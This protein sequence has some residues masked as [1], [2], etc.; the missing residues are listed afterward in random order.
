MQRHSDYFLLFHGILEPK[1]HEAFSFKDDLSRNIFIEISALFL[2]CHRKNFNHFV[3][4]DYFKELLQQFT[5]ISLSNK[6][7]LYL[8]QMHIITKLEESLTHEDLQLLTQAFEYLYQHK[9]LSQEHINKLKTLFDPNELKETLVAKTKS[10]SLEEDFLTQKEHFKE[11]LHELSTLSTSSLFLS[12]LNDIEE[13]INKQTFSIGITGVMNAGKSTL[14]NALMGA[15]ILGSSVI[16]ETANLSIVKYAK[17]TYAKV[18][19]WDKKEWESLENQATSLPSIEK[20]IKQTKDVFGDTLSQYIATP[21]VEVDIK[22]EALP[23][24]TSAEKSGSKCNLVKYVTLGVDLD[25]LEDGIEIVD[26]PGLDDPVIQR[27][28]ITKSYMR[29]CDLMIHLMNVSQSATYKDVEF[30]IDALIYQ[31]ISSLLIIITRADTVNQ[32][33]LDEVIA[34]TKKSIE[35]ELRALKQD[36]KVEHILSSLIFLPISGFM[37][38]QHKIGNSQIAIEAG[39]PLEKTGILEIE[40]YLKEM[41]FGASSTKNRLL[42]QSISHRIITTI[43]NEVETLH[44]ELTLLNKSEDELEEELS[45]FKAKKEQDSVQ[46]EH[47]TQDIHIQKQQLSE[48]IT[49]LNDFIDTALNKLQ[50][51]IKNRIIN[52]LQ[53]TLESEKHTLS[54]EDVKKLLVTALKDGIID[55]VRDYRN[56][57]LKKMDTISEHVKH[58]LQKSQL[59]LLDMDQTKDISDFFKDNFAANFLSSNYELLLNELSTP[60]QKA[61]LKSLDTLSQNVE[62]ILKEHISQLRESIIHKASELTQSLVSDFFENLEQ[63]LKELAST[64]KQHEQ[65]ISKHINSFNS[66]ESVKQQQALQTHNIIKKLQ[67]HLGDNS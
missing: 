36:S 25:F 19:Y 53:Y 48:Y 14:L 32:A 31:N 13:Y 5:D 62:L 20:F 35:K 18:A 42:I 47:L 29:E 11:H 54:K 45:T 49:S 66:N 39:F 7:E 58:K 63:P 30:I 2:I 23:L 28:E 9:L 52:D 59:T 67:A 61:K 34:Y 37:A 1:T 12:D 51:L 17:Q 24:Y 33:Q 27:E 16:P 10:L 65:I 6:E 38:L 57:C 55:I 15:E 60:I 8:L 50:A 41:L 21:M 3:S 44:Y 26:T 40:S 64:L 43:Q 22:L 46:L 4:L 56:L